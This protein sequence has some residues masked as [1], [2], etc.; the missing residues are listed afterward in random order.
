MFQFNNKLVARVAADMLMLLTDHVTTL[1]DKMAD[2]P[3]RIIEVMANVI[4]VLLPSTENSNSD[5]DKRVC[6]CYSLN[7]ILFGPTYIQWSHDGKIKNYFGVYPSNKSLS[8]D[9]EVQSS[10]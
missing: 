4:S 3:R 8:L 5:D 10:F 2:I 7:C 9:K 1:L 6:L